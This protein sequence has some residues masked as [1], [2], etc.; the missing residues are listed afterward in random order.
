V[1]TSTSN[2]LQSMKQG[3]HRKAKLMSARVAALPVARRHRSNFAEVE[4][5]CLFVGYPRSGH[6]L[7][8]SLLN[9]HP[10]AVI[11]HEL[12]VLAMVGDGFNRE[13]L[14]ASILRRD[15]WFEQ[16]GRRWTEFDYSVPGQHQGSFTQLRL[17]GDKK[18]GRTSLWL[19]RRP[20]LLDRL[21]ET[22]GVP[23]VLVHIVR[24]PYDNVA[25]MH[26][27]G[28][29]WE[30]SAASY[31]EMARTVLALRERHPSEFLVEGHLRD[32]IAAPEV[33]IGR[34]ASEVGLAPAEG[35]AEGC[36]RV[37]AGAERRSSKEMSWPRGLQQEL[38][39]QFEE[40]DFLRGYAFG[41]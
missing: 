40:I 7:V 30:D 18:G 4:R 5:F 34:L 14:F 39:R 15:R 29:T 11:S 33:E 22:V 20:E 37:I 12:D 23:V 1:T 8:G 25:T 32:L 28:S 6:S 17:I 38:A 10:H 9:A 3:L 24:N 31:L 36:A 2:P 13:Q 35:F 26:R 27:R 19:A 16:Q 41:G 21:E